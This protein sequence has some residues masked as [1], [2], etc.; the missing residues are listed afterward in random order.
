MVAAGNATRDHPD[1]GR[2]RGRALRRGQGLLLRAPPGDLPGVASA[3]A[4]SSAGDIVNVIVKAGGLQREFRYRVEALPDAGRPA[5]KKRVLVVAAE[6][7]KGVSPNVT[8]GYATAPRYLA[9]HVAAL[10]AARLRGRDVRRRRAAAERRHAQRR[11]RPADQVP[12]VPR[13][14]LAL[15]RGRLLDRRRLRPAG[16]RPIPTRAASPARRRRPARSEMAPWAHHAMLELRDYANEGGK[17]IVAGRNVHQAFTS[18]QRR[19]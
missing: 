18:T 16:R 1:D 3:P 13:R 10:E 2:P 19:A 7:Y 14:A 11:R 17:L 9:Q 8:P 15:R 5:A 12:D 6:D 4:T